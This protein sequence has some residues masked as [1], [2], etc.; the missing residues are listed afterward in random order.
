MKAVSLK[1]SANNAGSWL[2]RNIISCALSLI[3]IGPKDLPALA[4]GM[5]T[6][7]G[8]MRRIYQ[9]VMLSVRK[10]E[11]EIDQTDNPRPNNG[12]PDYFELL[13]EHIKTSL[14]IDEPLRDREAVERIEQEF[15]AAVDKIKQ[16]Q[17]NQP[18]EAQPSSIA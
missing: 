7:R 5:G 15:N 1:P 2:G 9:D 8:K 6:L 18:A 16:D 11:V 4:R 17:L 3:V 14:K 12:Q 13:P 10:L